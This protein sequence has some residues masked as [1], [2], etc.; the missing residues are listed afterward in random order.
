M[1]FSQIKAEYKNENHQETFGH[2]KLYNKNS[3]RKIDKMLYKKD[4][5]KVIKN[6]MLFFNL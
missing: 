6:Y 2:L 4:W 3:K 5:Q 1:A